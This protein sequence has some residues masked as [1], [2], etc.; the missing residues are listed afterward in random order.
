MGLTPAEATWAATR[1]G[2]LALGLEDRGQVT[3]GAVADLVVLEAGSHIDLS[4][5]PGSVEP[6][7]VLK[8]GVAV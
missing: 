6:W 2:A 1:G 4:Y 7:R 5:R 3:A 8:R